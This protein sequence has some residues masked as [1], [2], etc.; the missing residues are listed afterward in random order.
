[1]P[2]SREIWRLMALIRKNRTLKQSNL[3]VDGTYPGESNPQA[4]QTQ[5]LWHLSGRIEP[6]SR[7]ISELMALIRENRTLKQRDLRVDG[8]YPGKWYPQA[9]QT[10]T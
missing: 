4:E 5:T 9:E 1:M 8:T 6:S 2:S 7:G 3:R 10:Q